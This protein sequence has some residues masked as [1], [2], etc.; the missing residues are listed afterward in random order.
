M[1]NYEKL[2]TRGNESLDE[3][4]VKMLLSR[5]NED[6]DKKFFKTFRIHNSYF[7]LYKSMKKWLESEAE[8]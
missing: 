1:T 4:A 2:K 7:E 5:I 8:E 6:V 3:M